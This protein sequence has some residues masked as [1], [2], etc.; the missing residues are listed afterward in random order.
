MTR[1]RRGGQAPRGLQGLQKLWILGQGA[2]HPSCKGRHTRCRGLGNVPVK[3]ELRAGRDG[4]VGFEPDIEV[5]Q[6]PAVT[7]DDTAGHGGHV[8]P[9]PS[10]SA[11]PTGELGCWNDLGHDDGA[12]LVDHGRCLHLD[13]VVLAA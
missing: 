12:L 10:E 7:R 6:A 5:M 11:R 13:E 4:F 9:V 8:S 2:I 3:P 1:K